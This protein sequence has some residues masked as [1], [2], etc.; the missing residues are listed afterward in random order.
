MAA[1]ASNINRRIVLP[2]LVES[3]GSKPPMPFSPLPSPAVNVDLSR[4]RSL[5]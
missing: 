1:A 5:A 2:S 3:S 4:K